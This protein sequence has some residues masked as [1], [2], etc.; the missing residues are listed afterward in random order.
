MANHRSQSNPPQEP[1]LSGP[2]NGGPGSPGKLPAD[3]S[4]LEV[5]YL[6]GPTEASEAVPPPAEPEGGGRSDSQA[7]VPGPEAPSGPGTLRG[8]P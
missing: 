1:E 7:G 6:E 8:L 2:R 5:E 3:D 4:P